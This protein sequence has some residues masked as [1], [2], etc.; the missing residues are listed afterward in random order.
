MAI[1]L[2]NFFLGWTLVGWVAALVWSA[3]PIQPERRL[4]LNGA[5]LDRAAP[6][7]RAEPLITIQQRPAIK[8]PRLGPFSFA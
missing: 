5:G 4:T 1:L 6:H 7:R 3:L 2:L 8:G